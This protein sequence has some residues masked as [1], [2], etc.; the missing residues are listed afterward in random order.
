M[1]SLLQVL[2]TVLKSRLLN[3]ENSMGLL[4]VLGL[5]RLD[6]FEDVQQRHAIALRAV[7]RLA[8]LQ[9]KDNQTIARL[10]E[11]NVQLERWVRRLTAT[12]E[13]MVNPPRLTDVREID[14][15]RRN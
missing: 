6:D 4:R 11:D 14:P 13:L 5:A 3:L 2:Y 12:I 10:R 9:L 1:Q 8:G 7:E 15:K